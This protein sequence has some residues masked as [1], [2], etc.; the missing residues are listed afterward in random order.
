MAIVLRIAS[1]CFGLGAALCTP[2]WEVVGLQ[3]ALTILEH[4][5]KPK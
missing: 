3:T 5:A 4:L 1:R 2:Q